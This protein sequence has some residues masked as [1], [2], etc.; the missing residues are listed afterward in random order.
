LLDSL[1]AGRHLVCLPGT[2]SKHVE[3]EDGRI[4]RFHT[5][6]T[7][8]LFDV[9]CRHSLLGRLMQFPAPHDPGAFA[10]GVDDASK[11]GDLLAHLFAVRTKGLFADLEP[12]ALP[13]YLSGLLIGHELN[14]LPDRAESLHL[15]AGEPLLNRYHE[16]L[17]RR[18]FRSHSHPDVLAARGLFALAGR[19]NLR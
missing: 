1:S 2:H 16:A 17:C 11:A 4:E 9:L 19:R 10:T 15:I 8:E 18:G 5:A 6:M 14:D 12:S 3:V 13:S 7:G